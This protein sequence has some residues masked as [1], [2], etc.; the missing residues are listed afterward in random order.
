MI[1]AIIGTILSFIGLWG[2]FYCLISESDNKKLPD[3]FGGIAKTGAICI[4]INI[5]ISSYNSKLTPIE[6]Y[7]GKT[8]LRI[9]YEDSIPIDSIVVY[10]PEFRK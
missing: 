1:L 5:L 4:L 10:K 7:Q 8:T 2:L 6:V 3:I 9:T